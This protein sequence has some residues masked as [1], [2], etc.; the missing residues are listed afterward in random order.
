[1]ADG[2]LVVNK[3]KRKVICVIGGRLAWS[4]IIIFLYTILFMCFF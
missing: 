1:M 2:L 4:F 3:G